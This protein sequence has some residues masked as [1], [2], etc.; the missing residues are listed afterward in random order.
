MELADETDLG[1]YFKKKNYRVN[2]SLVAN[3]LCAIL[4]GLDVLHTTGITHRD[5]KPGNIL[6]DG[7]TPK[8]A[9]FGSSRDLFNSISSQQVRGTK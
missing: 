7:E 5:I 4:L 6:L 2:Q 9:D 3:W 8:I 1:K